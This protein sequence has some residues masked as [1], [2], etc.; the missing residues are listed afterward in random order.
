VTGNPRL[1]HGGHPLM[2]QPRLPQGTLDEAV[3]RHAPG[4]LAAARGELDVVPRSAPGQPM[5][6]AR[7]RPLP[8]P[9]GRPLTAYDDQDVIG[10]ARQA[11]S[12]P[13]HLLVQVVEPPM[14]Q[15]GEERTAWR[16]PA[17]GRLATAVREEDAGTHDAADESP[18]APVGQAASSPMPQQIMVH[19]AADAVQVA[20]CSVAPTPWWA[21]TLASRALCARRPGRHPSLGVLQCGAQSGPMTGALACCIT[22]SSPGGMPSGRSPSRWL[23]E[24][25]PVG[26]LPGER[27][28]C[29]GLRVSA[30]RGDGHTPGRCRWP[31]RPCRR[32][33]G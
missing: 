14:G 24:A 2:P 25:S 16:D 4:P 32:L 17:G 27:G 19:R 1:P 31:C 20:V 26:R 3:A 22:W 28:P 8:S 11:P 5:A 18:L 7:A 9:L 15:S 23:W 12:A 30:P 6:A 29:H 33:P 21:A 10:R 13:L